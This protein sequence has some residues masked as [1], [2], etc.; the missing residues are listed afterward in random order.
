MV[1]SY[2]IHIDV[3]ADVNVKISEWTAQTCNK[4][5]SVQ[6]VPYTRYTLG[7]MQ[8]M[9]ILCSVEL[10]CCRLIIKFTH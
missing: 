10:L 2:H 8:I 3:V 1:W 7:I 6:E 9:D 4:V 5:S